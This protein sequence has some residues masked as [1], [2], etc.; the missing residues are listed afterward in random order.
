MV[1]L[2]GNSEYIIIVDRLA[3]YSELGKLLRIIVVNNADLL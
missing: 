1:L 3:V 2:H